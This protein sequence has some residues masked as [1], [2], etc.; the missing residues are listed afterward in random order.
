MSFKI[1]TDISKKYNETKVIIEAPEMSEEVQNIIT[2]LSC[3]IPKQ[4]VCDRNNEIYFIDINDVICFF[5]N[6][7][8]NFVRTFDGEY[9]IRHKLYELEE[10]LDKKKFIRIS[11][12][13]I[14]NIN[15][16]SC[17][18]TSIIGTIVVK[19]KNK[20]QETVS[21]RNVAAIMK[22]LKERRKMI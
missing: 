15:Q 18:D 9:R 12:S 17:F 8:T 13:C 21:K 22:L 20:T 16:V 10:L 2:S 6:S 7:K 4:I 1:L 5:S 14:I 11:K 3:Q 19:F